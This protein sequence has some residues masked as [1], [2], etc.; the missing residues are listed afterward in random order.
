MSG[1]PLA[2]YAAPHEA[3][4]REGRIVMQR[5]DDCGVITYPAG[6]CCHACLSPA[7]TWAEMSGRGTLWAYV[8]YHH[9]FH[10]AFADKLPYNVALVRLEEGPQM[11]AGITGASN[12]ELRN[13]M[14]LVARF[15][16]QPDGSSL[17]KFRPDTDSQG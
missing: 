6:P 15:E 2:D 4:L 16:P 7:L 11:I 14:A 10:P 17:L 9:A 8:I 1:A 12:D 5:C 13:G 3:A